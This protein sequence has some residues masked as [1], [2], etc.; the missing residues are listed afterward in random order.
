[1]KF[2]TKH[3]TKPWAGVLESDD[4]LAVIGISW[5]GWCG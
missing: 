1:M 5:A 2:G 4:S 3:Y